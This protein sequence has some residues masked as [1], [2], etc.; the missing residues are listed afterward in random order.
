MRRKIH[1]RLQ[2]HRQTLRRLDAPALRRAIGGGETRDG[3]CTHYN[4]FCPID[5]C[6]CG[7]AGE[8]VG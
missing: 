5:T 1:R 2:L 6:T 8:A 3:E 4:S 7:P